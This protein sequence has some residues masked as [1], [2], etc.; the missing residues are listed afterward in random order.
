M[1]PPHAQQLATQT[2]FES[3]RTRIPAAI[4]VI[5]RVPGSAAHPHLP[6]LARPGR[7]PGVTAFP[8]RGRLPRQP[9]VR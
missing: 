6:P 3:L 2:W 7:A 4:E 8:L 5:E 1:T 9:D